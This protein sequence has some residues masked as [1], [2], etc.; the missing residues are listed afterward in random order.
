MKTAFG[1]EETLNPLNARA[2]Y[3]K[4]NDLIANDPKFTPRG[5][6]EHYNVELV[7]TTD[8]PIDSLEYHDV[9]A[10][11]PTCKTRMIPAWRPDAAMNIEAATFVDYVKKL[12]AVSDT[13]ITTF[14]DMVAAL[15]KRHDFFA[16]K[17]C[18]LSDHGIEEF[19][20]EPYTAQ[21]IDTILGKALAGTTPT[22]EEQRKYKHAFLKE[23][24]VMDYEAGWTQQFHY[25]A[26]RNNNTLMF[27]KLGADTG[28]DSIGEFT[29]AKA[30][31][32]F[33][34]ELNVEGK[35]TKTILYN[36][37]PCANEVIATMLGNFQDGSCP[38]KIQWGSGW[39]F[40]D[41]KDGME[42]Q[43]NAL[44]VL[45]LLSRFVGMLTDSRSF[46]SYPR[47]EYFR[48]TLCNLV[49][50]DIEN[51]LIPFEG[52]EE[53]RVRQMIEDICYNNAK[54]YFQF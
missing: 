3:D 46:L 18:K 45:G 39:W 21:E 6:M 48:R 35:L 54:N 41:Q 7:C 49:G 10:A 28:F 1:I 33:L 17:G 53:Q 13:S 43:M 20:D 52:Y 31:S 40:L 47:H 51:G 38:G 50:N 14:S 37:N 8:D 24:A 32:H 9:V 12:E 30:M 19:Y 44:S 27:N 36:L 16:S 2:I 15:Q 22:V 4:C 42:K 25:G 11:D 26:I 34:D 23:M 5:L 29:T